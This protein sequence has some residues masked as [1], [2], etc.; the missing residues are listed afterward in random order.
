MVEPTIFKDLQNL[1][2]SN[3]SKTCK[4]PRYCYQWLQLGKTEM[5]YRKK[6]LQPFTS[7]LRGSVYGP[8]WLLP[9]LTLTDKNSFPNPFPL[10]PIQFYMWYVI[11]KLHILLSRPDSFL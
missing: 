9:T 2:N 8:I 1:L 4:K 6:I 7:S 3:I 10:S 5:S 11:I